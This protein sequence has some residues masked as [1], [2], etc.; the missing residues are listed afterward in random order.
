MG[1]EDLFSSTTL[2]LAISGSLQ[3][4]VLPFV[5]NISVGTTGLVVRFTFCLINRDV[6]SQK[7][8]FK[9]RFL[10]NELHGCGQHSANIFYQFCPHETKKDQIAESEIV[11]PL[12][13]T[14]NFSPTGLF[15]LLLELSFALCLSFSL[16][17]CPHCPEPLGGQHNHPDSGVLDSSFHVV[18]SCVTLGKVT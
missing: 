14:S 13:P 18:T 7:S 4:P 2:W 9:L 6:Y 11:G 15:W 12:F 5:Q 10:E 17:S 8:N 16:L 1:G 3:C